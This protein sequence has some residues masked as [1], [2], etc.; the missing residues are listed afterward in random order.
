V[1]LSA[2]RRL[3][4]RRVLTDSREST[5]RQY[6]LSGWK[7]RRKITVRP[8][9]GAGTGYQ[10]K[11]TVFYNTKNRV[12][13]DFYHISSPRTA[14][15][16]NPADTHTMLPVIRSNIVEVNKTIDGQVRKY[17]AYDSNSDGTAVRLYYTNDLDGTWTPYSGNPLFSGRWANAVLDNGT[18]HL[19]VGVS[20]VIYRYTSTDGINFT[21]QEEVV[22][23]GNNPFCWLSPNDNKWYLYYHY[24]TGIYVK[25]ADSPSGFQN[26]SSTLIQDRTHTYAAPSVFYYDDQYWLLTEVFYNSTWMVRIETSDSPVS[27]FVQCTGTPFL[28]NN[29]ACPMAALSPDSSKCYLFLNRYTDDWYQDIREIDLSSGPWVSLNRKCK[30][31][32][33]DIRFTANDGVTELSYW[34]EEKVPGSHAV[35]W[36][37]IPNDLSTRSQSF[38]VYYGKGTASAASNGDNTFLFFD[39]FNDPIDWTNKW[40]SDNQ[41]LFSTVNG[42]LKFIASGV[43]LISTIK[44]FK[45]V[46]VKTKIRQS[47]SGGQAYF[48]IAGSP[49]TYN[50]NENVIVMADE[51]QLRS[52]INGGYN[53]TPISDYLERYYTVEYYSPVSGYARMQAYNKDSR[54]CISNAYTPT[55]STF[56][57]SFLSYLD[58]AVGYAKFIFVRKYVEPEPSYKE[59]GEE[60]T[61]TRGKSYSR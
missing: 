39:D 4:T 10:V 23:N 14:I 16:G 1:P 30:A 8:S 29:E 17:L 2:I 49:K 18:I 6:W 47:T 21:Q 36:I 27:N 25:V 40:Q 3:S 56:Y 11:L 28:M 45:G 32:F 19:F 24:D 55:V 48:D 50:G 7:Y 41:S 54:E 31:D 61:P 12:L 59:I 44:S 60:E 43:T 38:Y 37:K 15:S 57:P 42:E 20:G 5:S 13:L 51:S 33:G 26:A 35:F 22:S 46:A 9:Y 53:Y 34:I 52:Y 58:S